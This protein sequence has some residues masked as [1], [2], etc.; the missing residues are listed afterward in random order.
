MWRFVFSAVFLISLTPDGFSQELTSLDLCSHI[1]SPADSRK[2]GDDAIVELTEHLQS[3]R[4]VVVCMDRPPRESKG[5]GFLRQVTWKERKIAA[6]HLYRTESSFV[7]ADIVGFTA[8]KAPL[9]SWHADN[10][11]ANL[12][13]EA[14]IASNREDLKQ[15][16]TQI[17]T[18]LLGGYDS[19]N[20]DNVSIFWKTR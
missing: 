2:L 20:L 14:R 17:S 7:I 16:L 6:M 19:D 8:L 4:Q 1:D 5:H 15:D 18:D 13:S 3:A 12:V 11:T 10:G 9:G